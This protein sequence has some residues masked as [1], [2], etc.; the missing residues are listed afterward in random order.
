MGTPPNVCQKANEINYL[1]LEL[2]SRLRSLY[3]EC[4]E[5]EIERRSDRSRSR[6]LSFDLL[7]LRCLLLWCFFGV[8]LRERERPILSFRLCFSV[9]IIFSNKSNSTRMP[10]TIYFAK[11]NEHVKIL[12]NTCIAFDEYKMRNRFYRRLKSMAAILFLFYFFHL[13]FF[14]LAHTLN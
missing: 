13:F 2:R 14:A 11:M 5:I 7:F 3:F 6:S 12:W 1:D 10:R 8:R 4:D 9:A